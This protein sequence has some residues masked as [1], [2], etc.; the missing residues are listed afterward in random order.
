MTSAKRQHLQYYRGILSLVL[1]RKE[2]KLNL[3]LLFSFI[4]KL[5]HHTNTNY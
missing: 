4:I 2:I 1:L 3:T 5:F